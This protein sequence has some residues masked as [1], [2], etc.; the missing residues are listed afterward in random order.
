MA[1]KKDWEAAQARE[2]VP[3]RGAA[4]E[5][6]EAQAQAQAQAHPPAC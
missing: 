4:A 2:L 5:A 1:A 3:E 6:L